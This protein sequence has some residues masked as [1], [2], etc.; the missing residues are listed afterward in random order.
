[1]ADDNNKRRGS[2]LKINNDHSNIQVPNT[3]NE[4]AFDAKASAAKNKMEEHKQ[5]V[6]EL[7]GKF[8]AMI[9]DHTLPENKTIISKDLE[10]E[11]LDKLIEIATII[12]ADQVYPDGWGSSA[13][14]MLLMKMILLQ[15]DTLNSMAFKIDKLEKQL[16]TKL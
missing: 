6:W 10:K 4:A 12:N 14:E 3:T 8:K 9:E 1:M 2:G 7:S 15:R 5:T 13:L 11:V 16:F